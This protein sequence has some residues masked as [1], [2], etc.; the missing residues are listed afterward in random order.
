MDK[1]EEYTEIN[2]PC[3][4]CYIGAIGECS[5]VGCRYLPMSWSQDLESKTV[6]IA[7]GT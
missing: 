5:M 7:K 4:H 6:E 3:Y 2:N 1:N